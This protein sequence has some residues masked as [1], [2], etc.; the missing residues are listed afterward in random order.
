MSS[1]DITTTE[2]NNVLRFLN[3]SPGKNDFLSTYH[4][5]KF[6]Y[7]QRLDNKP[8][9]KTNNI[10]F[11]FVEQA[12]TFISYASKPSVSSINESFLKE[13]LTKVIQ[14]NTPEKLEKSI[15]KLSLNQRS[16]KARDLKRIDWDL[17]YDSYFPISYLF[18][19]EIYVQ[20]FE[21]N[22]ELKQRLLDTGDLKIEEIS[23]D[24]HMGIGKN[25]T[26]KNYLGKILMC[27]REHFKNQS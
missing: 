14:A 5:T 13:I 27:L 6:I 21:Q 19:F 23:S 15:P 10:E 22:P 24:H 3:S 18:M 26:G 20:K 12:L 11:N 1:E 17:S 9:G 7:S 25:K 4:N 2:D 16:G 8:G